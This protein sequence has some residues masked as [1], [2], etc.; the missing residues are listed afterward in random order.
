MSKPVARLYFAHD[1]ADRA[2][3]TVRTLHYYDRL[4]LLP[5]ATYT[6]AGYRLY[7]ERELA[8]L[9]QIVALKFVGLTLRQIKDVLDQSTLELPAV[10]RLQRQIVEEKRHRIDLTLRAIAEAERVL[11]D[12]SND[13]WDALKK[14]I[15]VIEMGENWDW[16]KR[17]STPEQLE[18]LAKRGT[19]DVVARGQQAW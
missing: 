16:V 3:V 5:P 15:E 14:I 19:P 2:G 13:R 6:E 9:E 8:R 12:D 18:E 11:L 1:F 7:G 4:G 10:L 17:Y